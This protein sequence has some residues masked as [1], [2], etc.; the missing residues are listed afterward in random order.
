MF[1]KD[2]EAKGLN[3]TQATGSKKFKNNSAK[4]LRKDR[5]I[6]LHRLG[7]LVSCYLARDHDVVGSNLIPVTEEC[8]QAWIILLR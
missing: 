8:E 2:P 4:V 5:S 6:H 1:P 7:R 3:L